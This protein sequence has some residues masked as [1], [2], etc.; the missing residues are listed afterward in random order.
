MSRKEFENILEENEAIYQVKGVPPGS[1]EKILDIVAKSAY[2]YDRAYEGCSRSVLAALIE[3][4][5]LSDCKGA[6]EAIKASTALSAGVARMGETCGALIG[7]MMGIGL[8]VGSEKL[9]DHQ[10]YETTMEYSNKL[11]DQFK[12]H[13]GTTTC[14]ELQEKIFG[15]RFDFKNSKDSEEWYKM[16]GLDKCPRVCAI[17]ARLAA[18]IILDLKI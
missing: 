14:F 10:A 11:C 12:E 16:D 7:G 1:R 13:Y 6:K 4:L 17:T 5:Q 3:H 8:V 18:N 9:E 15:R 2:N